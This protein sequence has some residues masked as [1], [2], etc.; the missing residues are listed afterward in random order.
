MPSAP[1]TPVQT[2]CAG[3][4]YNSWQVT[5]DLA[6]VRA[7]SRDGDLTALAGDGGQLAADAQAAGS[8]PAA[9]HRRAHVRL[10]AGHG[11]PAG[12]GHKTVAGDISRAAAAM[13]MAKGYLT[14]TDR[15]PGRRQL[16]GRLTSTREN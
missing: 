16:P 15:R 6:R 12:G 1:P 7:D 13:N 9:V 3:N 8:E 2:W 11:L 10:P 5:A 14:A 4:G